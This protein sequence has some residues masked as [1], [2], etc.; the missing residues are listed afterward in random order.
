MSNCNTW[1][2]GNSPSECSHSQSSEVYIRVVL[3]T[4]IHICLLHVLL[5]L[6][7]LFQIVLSLPQ[8]STVLKVLKWTL[9]KKS[10]RFGDIINRP[11]VCVVDNK[12]GTIGIM[13]WITSWIQLELMLF[14]GEKGGGAEGGWA[15]PPSPSLT[16]HNTAKSG[17][18][19]NTGSIS[20]M[21]STAA[22]QPI[23][24]GGRYEERASWKWEE[25]VVAMDMVS[26]SSACVLWTPH[27]QRVT[28][29]DFDQWEPPIRDLK[30]KKKGA[31]SHFLARDCLWV[32]KWNCY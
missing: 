8:L 24:S 19:V 21:R 16:C 1:W 4:L 17:G 7:G 22:L 13:I 31:L 27:A 9:T 12:Y 11:D 28:W 6:S 29:K 26:G 23:S 2:R 32:A 3:V 18:R 15:L 20:R 30:K 10:A 5:G 25:S 14:S